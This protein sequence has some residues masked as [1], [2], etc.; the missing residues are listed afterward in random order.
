[1]NEISIVIPVY[2][3]QLSLKLLGDK[4]I[5]IS[6]NLQNSNK[7]L[8]IVFVDD[9]SSDNSFMELLKFK[10]I[11]N[12]TKI[13]KLLKN[14][15]SNNAIQIGLKN[16]SGEFISVLSADLQDDPD[17]ILEMYSFIQKEKINLIICERNSR[18]D[19]FISVLFS[20]IFY[21]ILISY[22]V[23]N[24]PKNGFDV[25]MI[26][27]DLLNNLNLDTIN[28]TISLMIMTQ[29]FKY[30]KILYQRKKREFGKSQWTFSKK[31]NFF[32]D[33]FIRYSDLPIKII[34]RFGLFFSIISILYGIYILVTKLIFNINVE[35][36]ATL[37]ILVS[38][39]S[40]LIIFTL[41]LIGEYLIR[42]YKIVEKTEKVIIEEII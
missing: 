26:K 2:N 16:T 3:N 6:K 37:A 7:N 17:L 25:F 34:S 15:G 23:K 35:G 39:L 27:K 31:I 4:L 9:G 21:K 12:N 38:F 8:E 1:M 36:F 30:K 5:E 29:G 24:Y 11:Y 33:I 13:I 10:K 32:W 22:V 41:G 18:N 20:K 14:Y 19:N 40:G 28:P 42:I